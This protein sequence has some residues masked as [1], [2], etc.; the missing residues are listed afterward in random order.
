[1]KE[2]VEV[3]SKVLDDLLRE[4]K[5]AKAFEQNPAAPRI[6]VGHHLGF[7]EDAQGDVLEVADGGRNQHQLH[8]PSVAPGSTGL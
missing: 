5:S 4:V 7:L 6:F 2:A 1:M 3:D 8:P